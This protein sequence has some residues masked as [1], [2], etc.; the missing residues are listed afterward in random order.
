MSTVVQ[1]DATGVIEQI[2]RDVQRRKIFDQLFVIAGLLILFS[3]LSILV[4]L[5]LNLVQDGSPRFNWDFFANFPSRKPERAGIL[6]AWPF[7]R[8]RRG[9]Q[10]LRRRPLLLA[11]R[12][13]NLLR[14]HGALPVL[15]GEF[16]RPRAVD[17][18]SSLPDIQ[19]DQTAI[20]RDKQVRL[21]AVN[22]Q[23]QAGERNRN[24]RNAQPG[25]ADRCDQ[26]R[27][28]QHR[29]RGR[30]DQAHDVGR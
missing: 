11:F 18:D 4:V 12:P 27:N 14:A 30:R 28:R 8:P 9:E 29:H 17:R 7:D 2:R 13:H 19:P 20:L 23:E 22:Q 3:A 5:F 6:S 25:R 16:V 10:G 26:Q 24:R 15:D 1:S 21:G